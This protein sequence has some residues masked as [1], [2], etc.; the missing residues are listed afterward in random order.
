MCALLCFTVL[1]IPTG[2]DYGEGSDATLNKVSAQAALACSMQL[3][4]LEG[5]SSCSERNLLLNWPC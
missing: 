1:Q 2:T 3:P 4:A 5:S